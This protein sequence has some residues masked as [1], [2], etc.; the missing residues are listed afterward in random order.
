[1]YD[2]EIHDIPDS[3]ISFFVFERVSE[4]GSGERQFFCVK[5]VFS[6]TFLDGRSRMA[7]KNG[8]FGD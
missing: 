1:M 5:K 8:R 6:Q 7:T 2:S 3:Q 4:G